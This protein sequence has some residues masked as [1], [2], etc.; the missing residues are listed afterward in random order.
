MSFLTPA[1]RRAAWHIGTSLLALLA[2]HA[3]FLLLGVSSIA[4]AS[5]FLG[6]RCLSFPRPCAEVRQ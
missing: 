3:F 4:V 2:G 6:R 1:S 5:L